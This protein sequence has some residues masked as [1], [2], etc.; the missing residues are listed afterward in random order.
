MQLVWRN[1][2]YKCELSVV[3]TRTN[4]LNQNSVLFRSVNLQISVTITNLMC[5]EVRRSRSVSAQHASLERY[6][7][8]YHAHRIVDKALVNERKL[9]SLER[10]S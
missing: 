7:T 1:A 10:L 5:F 9:L 2:R 8:C 6:S 3:S 4:L